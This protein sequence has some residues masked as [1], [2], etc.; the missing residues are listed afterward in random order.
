MLCDERGRGDDGRWVPGTSGG[1]GGQQCS[2]RTAC[3]G[4][5][6]GGPGTLTCPH[7]A[8]QAVQDRRLA[9]LTGL[10]EDST[11]QFELPS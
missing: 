7:L 6:R 11:S 10:L 5:G 3:G 8:A 4:R 2:S 9:V 1:A